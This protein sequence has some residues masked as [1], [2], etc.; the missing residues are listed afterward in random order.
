MQ[1][2][3]FRIQ[4]GTDTLIY[5]FGDYF[6]YHKGDAGGADTLLTIVCEDDQYS[7]SFDLYPGQA[8]RIKDVGSRWRLTNKGTV[9]VSGKALIGH[10]EL[11]DN[12]IQGDVSVV[13]VSANRA[14]AGSA[15][16]V[17]NSLSVAGGNVICGFVNDGTASRCVSEIYLNSDAAR[18]WEIS[19]GNLWAGTEN[20]VAGSV[21]A[22]KY[23]NGAPEDANA[24]SYRAISANPAGNGWGGFL[25][26]HMS[27]SPGV[28]GIWTPKDSV[29]VSPGQVLRAVALDTGGA[30]L[31]RAS[32]H[33][34]SL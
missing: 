29:V 22:G 3:D 11:I 27:S 34:R 10:G 8:V 18:I 32:F 24:Q 1:L 25:L 26:G 28:T 17:N 12:R 16:V 15:L 4:P 13:D 20:R 21:G 5:A 2:H 19:I 33:V 7:G 30:V 23:K 31:A 14:L 6:R 9:T